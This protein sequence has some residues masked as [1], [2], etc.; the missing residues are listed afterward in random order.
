MTVGTTVIVLQNMSIRKIIS[1]EKGGMNM[2]VALIAV[3]FIVLCALMYT[4]KLN[5]MFAL[6]IMA[7]LVA[8]I[9]GIPWAD[10]V[11]GEVTIPGIQSLL[12]VSGPLRLGS[13]IITF[14]FGAIL[15]Q[16]VKNA[17]I[18]EAVIRK[19][20]EMAGDRP[21]ILSLALYVVLALL[22]TTLGGLG[23]IMML[24][25]IVLPIMISLGITPLA[26]AGILLFATSVGGVFNLTNWSLYINTLGLS[27]E[28]VREFAWFAGIIF[29]L[30][31]TL[32]CIV[33]VRFGG[34]GNLFRKNQRHA[35][36][37]VAWPVP[38]EED[39]AKAPKVHWFSMLTPLVPLIVVLG[40]GMSINVGFIAA[41]VY[42]FITTL[43]KGSMQRL[44]KA[45]TDGIS[46]SAGAIFLL[47]GIGMLLVVVMDERVSAILGPAMA[48]ILP[49]TAVAFVVFFSILAPLSLYR[50]PL[51]IWGLGLGLA[52][53]ML[54][55]GKLSATSIMAALMTTGQ[56]QGVCDPTNTQNVWTA[57]ATGVDVNDIMKKTLPYVWLGVVIGLLVA[58][59]RYF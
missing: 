10:T 49:S 11:D 54:S 41:I 26:A 52:G 43:G 22:F 58:A 29:G 7:L 38:V 15:S 19:V 12:F 23:S 35:A 47:I 50:G 3:V 5:A 1:I 40:F 13:T 45:I 21:L 34:L 56:I 14:I 6:P 27:V 20:S 9:A 37:K 4:K 59:I 48:A 51:N 42:C 30:A 55:A 31:G 44:S 36:E 17:G 33:E 32:F 16:Q 24:G 18:A 2:T 57:S 28:T 46:N 8:L 53:V 39:E 25:S